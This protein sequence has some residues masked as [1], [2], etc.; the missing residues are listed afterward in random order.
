MNERTFA[1]VCFTVECK[2]GTT[3]T[4]SFGTGQCSVDNTVYEIEATSWVLTPVLSTFSRVLS[5][6]F[7]K[8]SNFYFTEKTIQNDK[9]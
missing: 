3:I 8:I 7:Q 2:R 9:M 4:D 6:Y 1:A 5:D